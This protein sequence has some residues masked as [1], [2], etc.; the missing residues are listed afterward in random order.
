MNQRLGYRPALD[1]IRALSV[2]AVILYHADL[3]W[4]PGGFL[5][6]EV[7]FVVSGFL[8]TALLLGEHADTGSV[9]LSQ[10]WLRR[11][12]RLLPALFAMLT[13]VLVLSAFVH[14]DSAPDLR[15]DVLPSVFYVS[16]WWQVYG[17]DEPYFAATVLPVLRHLW[18]LAVEEQWYVVWPIAAGW[19]LRRRVSIGVVCGT[20]AVAVMVFT[21]LWV[22]E[23]DEFRMN[24]LYL[25]TLSRSSGLLVGA[26][27]A[28]FWFRRP[29]FLLRG[30]DVFGVLVVVGLVALFVSQHVDSMGLYRGGLAAATVGSAMLIVAAMGEGRVAR[31]FAWRPLA[32]VGRRSYGLY[33]WHWPFFVFFDARD[34]VGRLLLAL[35]VTIVVNEVVFRLVETPARRA[36]WWTSW[37]RFD[38]RIVSV[39]AL[40]VVVVLV[41]SSIAVMR[42]EARNVAIDS[43]DAEVVFELPV[44]ST[45]STTLAPPASKAI[46]PSTTTTT[47][48]PLPPLPRRVAIVGDSQAYALWVNRPDGIEEFF[49]LS[50]GSI[51][52]CGV[53]EEGVGWAND[54]RFRR[55][56]DG[57]SGFAK[58]WMRAVE[59]NDAEIALVVLGA[60]E[61]LDLK[62]DGMLLPVGTVTT[63]KI[64]ER[65]LRAAID[66]L[67]F[68]GTAVALLEIP[69]FRPVESWDDPM[70][71]R[72][73]DAGGA[74]LNDMMR[75]IAASYQSGV[76]FVDGPDEWCSDSPIA[77][78]L[79]YRY[80][81]VH[82]YRPGAKLI[83]ETI[84][85]QLL[86][87]PTPSG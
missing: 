25:G 23:G 26:A 27:L 37:R 19:M 49:D 64:F 53:Y 8:I 12:R 38:R 70:A 29:S 63:D 3:P 83:F 69:C 1:G 56:F 86:R 62:I 45:V 34:S 10:F 43:S 41:A 58:R 11:A 82:V 2:I 66:T 6:V 57:C 78:D 4:I 51:Q 39:S 74:H 80:D 84:A 16:N 76:Q 85:E 36:E 54:G 79:S 30:A 68:G 77:T 20:V 50:D 65:Q 5:G 14:T 59:R 67:L 71:E 24:W 17:I 44:A 42:T 87:I 73:N 75:R 21:A 15:R 60:W 52:G 55:P 40:V 35:L 48:A 31:A 22:R 7:F 28:W 13:V 46:A 33:L 47:A 9:N 18:S 81:G 72:A 32:E 61:L